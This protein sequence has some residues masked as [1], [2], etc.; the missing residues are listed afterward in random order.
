MEE[1][2]ALVSAA[3]GGDSAAFGRIVTRFQNMAYAGAYARLG[4]YHLAQDVAQEAFV[5]AYRNLA[6]LRDPA[7]FPGW[8]RRFVIKHADRQYRA[9][10]P[11]ALDPGAVDALPSEL[12][13]PAMLHARSEERQSVR[14]AVAALP[15]SQR[16]ATLLFHIEGYS[17]KQIAQFLEVPV[18]T[19]KKRLFDARKGLRKRMLDMVVETMQENKPDELFSEKVQF[20]IAL[21]AG[22]MARIKT[23]VDKRPELVE[24]RTEWAVS[25]EGH[26]WPLNVTPIFWAASTGDVKLLEFLIDR[27]AKIE[28]CDKTGGTSLHAAVL[29]GQ[30]NAATLLL[31]RGA[32]VNAAS[33]N[34]QQPLHRAVLRR[35]ASMVALLLDRGATIDAKDA[36]GCTPADWAGLKAYG[37]L[38]ELLVSR[39]AERPAVD[40]S[41]GQVTQRSENRDARQVPVGAAVLGRVLDRAGKAMDGK[42]A[43]KGAEN[44]P[45]HGSVD[46]GASPVF[47]TGIKIIDLL[48]PIKRGGHI[49]HFTPLSGVGKLLVMGQICQNIAASHNGHIVY[50]GLEDGAYTAEGML[51][52]W[53]SEFGLDERVMQ[54]TTW[55][56]AQGTDSEAKKQQ[57]VETGVTIAEHLRQ[58]GGEVLLVVEGSLASVAGI[59]SY[60]QSHAV[61]S[62]TGSVTTLYVGDYTAGLEPE[63]FVGLHGTITFSLERAQQGLYPAIDP[64][65]SRSVLLRDPL[66]DPEHR[67]LVVEIQRIFRRYQG[68]HNQYENKG[69]DALFHLADREEDEQLVRRARRLHRFLTQPFNGTEP[70]TGMPGVVVPLAETL[71]GCRAI[72]AGEHDEVAEEA[73]YFSGS[74]Q[75]VLEKVEATAV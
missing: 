37:D 21:R 16:E 50:L 44:A 32:D 1:L 2:N 31:D 70:Y 12:P 53:K 29:A 49:G 47:E 8:F 9:L 69:F 56:F 61:S 36:A 17:Q 57:A 24:V 52:A 13:D 71:E 51:L 35:D 65:E 43:V 15:E 27:G 3:Q 38:L 34:G 59:R 20:F 63:A 73:F 66:F 25:S 45:V 26:Y 42:G 74:M 4:D 28:E 7:A 75:Q 30:L 67:Q 46:G 19:I 39:G 18:G 72:L 33:N 68:L 41:S 40:L 14:E 23:L 64:Q 55:V 54:R 48:A 62:P 22:D 6:N 60:L 10:R 11:R 5:D 58:Q